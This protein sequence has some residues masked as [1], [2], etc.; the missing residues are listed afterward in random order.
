MHTVII[1]LFGGHGRRR[2]RRHGRRVPPHGIGTDAQRT[3]SMIA[4]WSHQGHTRREQWER[5]S[6]FDAFF[7]LSN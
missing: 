2:C 5:R 7:L 1:Q 6:Y 4:R 3:Q